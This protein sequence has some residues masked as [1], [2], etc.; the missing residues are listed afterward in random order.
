MQ[1]KR[2][3]T[4]HQIGAPL[5][6]VTEDIK[7]D[8]WL[9]SD[10]KTVGIQPH[11]SREFRVKT[12]QRIQLYRIEHFLDFAKQYISADV[13]QDSVDDVKAVAR[14]DEAAAKNVQ[15]RS[16]SLNEMRKLNPEIWNTFISIL[17]D[18]SIWKLDQRSI[19]IRKLD[20]EL[21]S[22]KNIEKLA[23]AE[24]ESINSSLREYNSVSPD[25]LGGH[26]IEEKEGLEIKLKSEMDRLSRIRQ[27]I[28]DK[29][30]EKASI[31]NDESG[32]ID[33]QH[34]SDL[35]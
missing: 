18:P 15:T 27:S 6:F 8:W 20:R 17:S 35:L 9:R 31:K 3:L 34:K 16:I 23:L 10:G 25:M 32:N 24:I 14:R 12:G 21:M 19:R 22:L 2:R 5:I 1:K 33:G 28:A 26:D 4:V 11:L 30:A 7:E 13:S 29:E